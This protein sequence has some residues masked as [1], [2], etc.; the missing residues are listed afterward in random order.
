MAAKP[1][2]PRP[3]PRLYLATPVVDDPSPLIASLPA[4]LAGADIAAV[5]LR[6][7][8]GR[9]AQ[10]DL[11][12]QGAGAGGAEWRRGAIDRGPCRTGRPRRRRRRASD[13]H[14]G[15][16]GGAADLETR[17][18]RR[19]RRADHPPRFDGAG[20]AGA[21]YV[22]FGEPDGKRAAAIGGRDCGAAAVVGRT[23]RAALCRLCGDGRRGRANLPRPARISCWS[24]ISSGPIRAAPRRR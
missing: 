7:E 22:L 13:R 14:R 8:A 20:E 3:L 15:D 21:D 2:P 1:A 19:R 4:L 18:H 16:A 5:L 17:P 6:L 9:S 23:V 11:A 10:H 24:A 12:H